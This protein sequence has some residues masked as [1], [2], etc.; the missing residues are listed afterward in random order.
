M[1]AKPDETPAQRLRR[2]ADEIEAMDAAILH[3][4][5]AVEAFEEEKL[6]DGGPGVRIKEPEVE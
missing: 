2:K 5:Y 6:H 1:T 3:L 4:R